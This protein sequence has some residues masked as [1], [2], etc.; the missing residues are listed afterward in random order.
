MH[1]GAAEPGEVSDAIEPG[2]WDSLV[3]VWGALLRSSRARGVWVGKSQER[4]MRELILC[5]HLSRHKLGKHYIFAIFSSTHI[6]RGYDSCSVTP[7]SLAYTELHVIQADKVSYD[8]Q[9]IKAS[10]Q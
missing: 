4:R 6:S 5:D 9:E 1:G 7:F 8:H 10:I 3:G 2:V